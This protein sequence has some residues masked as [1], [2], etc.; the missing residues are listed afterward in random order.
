MKTDNNANTQDKQTII[1]NRDSYSDY[2]KIDHSQMGSV[3]RPENEANRNGQN[4]QKVQQC[5]S[6]EETC[7]YHTDNNVCIKQNV[8]KPME[9]RL[10]NDEHPHHQHYEAMQFDDYRKDPYVSNSIPFSSNVPCPK[11]HTI[12]QLNVTS[13]QN[14]LPYSESI[15]STTEQITN[16][17]AETETT[18]SSK[19]YEEVGRK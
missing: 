7:H 4:F 2:S 3:I 1:D 17:A 13:D 5:R 6:V 18:S 10:D 19:Q 9:F 8:E 14:Q 11:N 15:N 12:V 16:Y